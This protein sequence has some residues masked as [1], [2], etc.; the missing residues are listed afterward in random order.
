MVRR[1]KVRDQGSDEENGERIR[2]SSSILP[3]WVHRIASLDALRPVLD[4]CGIST[5][6]C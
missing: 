4:L 1:A 6:E 2:F 3:K 5:G